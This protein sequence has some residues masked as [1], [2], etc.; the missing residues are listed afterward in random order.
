MKEILAIMILEIKKKLWYFLIP[1]WFCTNRFESNK[2]YFK[3][4]LKKLHDD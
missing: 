4:I 2:S 1:L 3:E